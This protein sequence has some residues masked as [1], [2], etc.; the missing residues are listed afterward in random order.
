VA[1]VS[2]TTFSAL[3]FSLTV[4]GFMLLYSALCRVCKSAWSALGLF[5]PCVALSFVSLRTAPGGYLAGTFSYYAVGPLR[6]FGLFLL[7][8]LSVWYL[9]KPSL[10][11]LVPVSAIAFFV[12]LNNL[13]FGVPSAVGVLA[14]AI[15]FPP[16]FRSVGIWRRL[17]ALTTFLASAG[18]SL[19]AYLTLVRIARGAWPTLG[20]L[21][22]FQKVFAGYGFCMLPAPDIGLYW[23]VYLTFMASVL[24]PTYEVFMAMPHDAEQRRLNG[25]LAYWG[26]AGMGPLTYYMG[27]S[28]S[29]V[30]HAV[31]CAWAFALAN[32]VCRAW[33]LWSRHR[34]EPN[35]SGSWLSVIPQVAVVS[36]FAL[37]V[38]SAGDV[39]NPLAQIRRLALPDTRIEPADA[40]PV[41]LIKKY[42]HREE[43]TMIVYRDAHWLALKAGVSN[44]FAFAHPDSIIILPQID[45]VV[46]GLARLPVGREYIFG[47]LIGDL[48][49]RLEALGFRKL[50]A[51]GDFAVW[52]KP[53]H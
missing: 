7:A 11:R 30:L 50:E 27:R 31:L 52:A 53:G 37:M 49:G 48:R 17:L 43:R 12:A 36:L 10:S 21:F 22:L 3:M 38:P 16:A 23:V 35:K 19:A 25:V 8:R 29:E 47:S 32:L 15:L 40:K 33:I 13:D 20:N 28:H 41:A 51:V 34:N 44:V 18:V 5:I 39:P 26:I 6:Y 45:T 1:G 24:I 2:V 42:V 14:C 9:E 4:V 46:A